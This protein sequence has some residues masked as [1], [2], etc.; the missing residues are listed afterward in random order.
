MYRRKLQALRNSLWV[1][2]PKEICEELTLEKGDIMTV[3][4]LGEKIIMTHTAPLSKVSP[5]GMATTPQRNDAT[6]QITT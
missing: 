3:E 6:C 2:V 4:R 1:F 5:N